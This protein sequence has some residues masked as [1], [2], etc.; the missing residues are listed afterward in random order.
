MLFSPAEMYCHVYGP[1]YGC[2][3]HCVP[4]V[5]LQVTEGK[6]SHVKLKNCLRLMLRGR[7]SA[8]SQQRSGA[9]GWCHCSRRNS[10]RPPTSVSASQTDTDKSRANGL[11]PC[12]IKSNTHEPADMTCVC[13]WG[14]EYTEIR[15][16]ENSKN[17]E[18]WVWLRL[19]AHPFM[20]FQEFSMS[21]AVYPGIR[22]SPFSRM[23]ILNNKYHNA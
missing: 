7:K 16:I 20:T 17:I 8:V 4:N 14:R 22:F 5:Q 19:C 21:S 18:V 11:K 6:G 1:L 23:G 10:S 12:L 9:L 13:V 15:E 3:E 2:L